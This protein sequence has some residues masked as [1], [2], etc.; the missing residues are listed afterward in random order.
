MRAI[1]GA[2]IP[3]AIAWRRMLR[4]TLSIGGDDDYSQMTPSAN[5]LVPLR[6]GE[7][8]PFEHFLA[9]LAVLADSGGPSLLS[10][11]DSQDPREVARMVTFRVSGSWDPVPDREKGLFLM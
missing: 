4:S 8:H 5:P 7:K 10:E 1:A 2:S 3:L 6:N 9:I 11:Q